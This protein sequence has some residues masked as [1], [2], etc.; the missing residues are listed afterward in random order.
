MADLGDPRLPRAQNLPLRTTQ[1][2]NAE[3]AQE[4]GLGAAAES[5]SDFR[6]QQRCNSR[7]AARD[8][9]AIC[10]AMLPPK[11]LNVLVDLKASLLSQDAPQ[12][13]RQAPTAKIERRLRVSRKKLRAQRV[14][15]WQRSCQRRDWASPVY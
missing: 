13:Q 3:V 4:R 8:G 12:T 11:A 5:V 10:V 15:A 2:G 14:N 9:A 1:A 6:R 7:A